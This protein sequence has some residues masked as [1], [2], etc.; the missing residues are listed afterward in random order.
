MKLTEYVG[1]DGLGLAALI[2]DGEVTENEV[3]DCAR[4]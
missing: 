2:R 4:H 3:L 1:H